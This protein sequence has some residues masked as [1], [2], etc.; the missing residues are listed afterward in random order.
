MVLSKGDIAIGLVKTS[1][2]QAVIEMLQE[3]VNEIKKSK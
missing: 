2:L 1:N 3:E